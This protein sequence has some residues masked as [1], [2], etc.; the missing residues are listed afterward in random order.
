MLKTFP[1]CVLLSLASAALADTNIVLPDAGFSLDVAAAM[2]SQPSGSQPTNAEPPEPAPE[3]KPTELGTRT[4]YGLAGK[5]TYQWYATIGA[6]F[7]YNGGG[8]NEGNAFVDFSVFFAD[9]LEFLVELGAWYIHQPGPD[10]GSGSFSLGVRFHFYETLVEGTQERDWTV[11]AEAA[12]GALF[13]A[14]PVPTGGENVAFLPRVGVGFT[15]RLDDDLRLLVA[16]RWNHVSNGRIAGDSNNP[17]LNGVMGVV[18]FV[19]PF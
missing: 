4:P 10:T 3:T 5:D 15:K 6:G 12:V 14:N 2:A 7:A 18:G 17:A 16:V 8:N 13:S 19:I 1:L 9:R 11:F